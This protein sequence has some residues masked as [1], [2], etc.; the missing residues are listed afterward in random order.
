MDRMLLLTEKKKKKTWNQLWCSV[1]SLTAWH[2]LFPSGPMRFILSGGLISRIQHGSG[3]SCRMHKYSISTILIPESYHLY[4]TWRCTCLG[5]WVPC[6]RKGFFFSVEGSKG[7]P[8][9]PLAW[10]LQIKSASR[11]SLAVASLS[12]EA[13]GAPSSLSHSRTAWQDFHVNYVQTW[14][15]SKVTVCEIFAFS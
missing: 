3:W 8:S 4:A 1:S 9:L 14:A 2:V 13:A 12:L 5:S 11:R 7:S 15:V 10:L 6:W